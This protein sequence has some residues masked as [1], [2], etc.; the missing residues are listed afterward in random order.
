MERALSVL[1]AFDGQVRPYSLAELSDR[2]RLYKSTLLRILASLVAYGYVVRLPDGRYQLGPTPFRLG[3]TYQRV[4][5]LADV[6]LP[7]MRDLV[8]QGTESPSFHVRHDGQHRLC[9][10]R[11]DS[12]HSTL[13][14]VSAGMLLPLDRG[15]AG[16]VILAFTGAPGEALDEIRAR[17]LAYSHG[18]RDPEC[19]GLACPVFGA[20]D[21]LVGA[22]SLSGPKVRFNREAVRRM[23]ELLVGAAV[24]LTAALGGDPRRVTGRRS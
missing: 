22:L 24:R 7:V 21:Q 4:S 19:A 9:T 13:D 18:E 17:R 1:D 2:T 3:A 10:L 6:I 23:T 15:A 5:G 16:K 11:V 12:N 20:G 8:A 14:T